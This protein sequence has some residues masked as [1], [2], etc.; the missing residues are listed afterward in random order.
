VVTLERGAV[1]PSPLQWAELLAVAT[2]LVWSGIRPVE[3]EVWLM[4]TVPVM[5]A[6]PLVAWRWRAFPWTGT[7]TG[8]MTLFAIALG[9]GGHYTYGLVPTGIWLRDHLGLGRNHYDR[10]GHFLQGV[11]PGMLAREMLLRCTALRPGKALFWIV[12]SIATAISA[13]YEIVEWWT[14]LI[15]APDSG[16]AFLGAQ[17]DI[18]DAQWDMSCAFLGSVVVQLL[19]ARRHDRQLAELAEAGR[20]DDGHER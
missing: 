20:L 1:R 18:W 16:I 12:V 15:V 3:R 19:F 8:L 14:T 17:G 10:L 2:V 6:I 5:L 9:I 4:E 13:V 7:A 11:V